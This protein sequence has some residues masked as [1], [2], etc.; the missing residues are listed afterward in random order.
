VVVHFDLNANAF[1]RE[2]HL[3]ADVLEG[4][5][6]RDGKVAFLEAGLI[7]EVGLLIA[8][9][10]PL[11][12]DTVDEVVAAVLSLVEANI[13]QDEELQFRADVDGVRDLR[14]LDVLLGLAGDEPRV[15]TVGLFS[16]GVFDI[17]DDGERGELTDRIDPRRRGVRNQDHVRL[18]DLL[19]PSD[20]GAV[21]PD[22]FGPDGTAFQDLAR[23]DRE[24]LPEPRQ[25]VEL[26]V[27]DL[28]VVVLDHLG[29][30]SD[31]LWGHCA[32]LRGGAMR[33]Y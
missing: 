16:E 28:D 15:A 27:D 33:K 4:V 21:E 23:G 32:L 18:L 29:D 24:V 26:E 25:V 10:V 7:A 12:L 31:V 9:G 14:L 30:V 17:T 8:A 20:A 1:H 13:V 2:N 22:A 6:W 19:K 11:T 5:V 3:A